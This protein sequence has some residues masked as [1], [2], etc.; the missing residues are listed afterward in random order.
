MGN[1]DDLD[2]SNSK[3]KIVERSKGRMKIT[4]KLSKEQAEAFKNFQTSVKPD[5]IDD[6]TFYRQIFF[7]GCKA[8]SDELTQMFHEHRA[9]LE[10]Q[11]AT[12]EQGKTPEETAPTSEPTPQ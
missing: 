9:K 12:D 1:V 8:I 10:A 5:G 3:V 2:F 6:E 11:K 7:N 4:F